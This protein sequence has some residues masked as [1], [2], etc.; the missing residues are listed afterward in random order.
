MGVLPMGVCVC[1][2]F[3]WDCWAQ[4]RAL[5]GLELKVIVSSHTGAEN[6]TSVFWKNAQCFKLL[7]HLSS[8]KPCTSI[9]T[10]GGAA[11][12]TRMLPQL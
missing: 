12:G 9:L 4:K 8:L 5:L 3:A 11:Q 7:N 10:V 2:M 6:W 1:T